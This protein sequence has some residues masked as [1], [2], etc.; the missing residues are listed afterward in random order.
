MIRKPGVLKDF[1]HETYIAGIIFYK[2]NF[3]RFLTSMRHGGLTLYFKL[4]AIALRKGCDVS[5]GLQRYIVLVFF[6]S[7]LTI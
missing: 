6:A 1:F 3:Y 7:Q 2:Q 4:V 5:K